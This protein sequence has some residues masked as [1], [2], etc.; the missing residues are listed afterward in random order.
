MGDILLPSAAHNREDRTDEEVGEIQYVGTEKCD[1]LHLR[2][3]T[4]LLHL[5]N[6]F[7][8]TKHSPPRPSGSSR[9]FLQ[10]LAVSTLLARGT[11]VVACVP[12]RTVDTTTL[13]CL[14]EGGPRKQVSEHSRFMSC[15]AAT[16]GAPDNPP[17][18]PI[19]LLPVP[20]IRFDGNIMLYLAT[21][22]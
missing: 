9:N 15:N 12:H 16:R 5:L 3:V 1:D 13:F 11:D 20:D 22:W 2:T 10:M 19:Q 21:N 14:R 8:E 4:T 18:A 17:P 7:D 6:R